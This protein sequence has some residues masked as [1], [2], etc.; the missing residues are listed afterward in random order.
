MK[1]WVVVFAVLLLLAFGK[2]QTAEVQP[3]DSSTEIRPNV[4]RK[5][6][7]QQDMGSLQPCY[8]YARYDSAG[9][10]SFIRATMVFWHIPGVATWCSK[11]GQ[12]IWQRCFGYARLHDA[13]SIPVADT[14]LFM[15]AS[16]SKTIVATAAMQVWERG[17]FNLDDD[18]NNYL[19]FSVRNPNYPDS[20]ITFRMLMTHTS[21][22]R[23]NWT[24]LDSLYV[25]GGDSPIALGY[26]LQSY[27]VPGG[28]YYDSAAN[29][30]NWSPGHVWEY[31]SVAVALLG[32]LVETIE[33]SFPIHC[34]D[35]IFNP[36]SMHETSWFLAGLD[37]NHIAV[38]YHWAGSFYQPYQHYGYPDYPDGQLRT[39]SLQLARH[40]TAIMHYGVA[41]SVRI[42]D[43][44]TVTLMRTIQYQVAPYLMMGLIWAYWNTGTRWIWYHDGADYGVSTVN[45]FCPA[46][47]SAVIV[48]TNGESWYGTSSIMNAI[49][50]YALQYGIEEQTIIRPRMQYGM[51]MSTIFRGPLRLPEGRSCRVFDIAG[52]VVMPDKMKP[53]I[54]FVE[55][56]GKI[57]RKVVKVR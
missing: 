38:P 5:S 10:D 27:F 9:L 36:L 3:G 16:I 14:T 15:L 53:G 20:I 1:S 23:D 19:P 11:N 46:E 57:T 52:R 44:A 34:Q 8:S 51:S 21:S 39:S 47:S 30:Y 17:E 55:I 24:V 25:W 32:Y 29:F 49:F 33:D 35:S 43:S 2:A 28:V 22:I 12:V 41:D 42:L 18:I 13:D 48:L 26:F 45:A 40:L 37:T 31:N 7:P 6:G 56:D 50:D 4:L 54:Y